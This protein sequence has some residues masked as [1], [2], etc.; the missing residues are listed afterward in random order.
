MIQHVSNHT[1]K[2]V[3]GKS[4]NT[5]TLKSLNVTDGSFPNQP[6]LE[7][8]MGALMPAHGRPIS[9]NRLDFPFFFIKLFFNFKT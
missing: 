2:A 9:E 3:W 4:L 8:E 7:A 6:E 5:H 1:V